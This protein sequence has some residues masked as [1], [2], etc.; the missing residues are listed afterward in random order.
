MM[1][2]WAATDPVP[3]I[4]PSTSPSKGLFVVH[5]VPDAG[6][7]PGHGPRQPI[8]EGASS[9]PELSEFRSRGGGSRA[10]RACR[11]GGG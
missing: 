10:V 5:E 9:A 3:E 1:S 2:T 11:R 6:T 4:Q 8:V 7:A